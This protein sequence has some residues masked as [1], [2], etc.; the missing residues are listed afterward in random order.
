M[1]SILDGRAQKLAKICQ[2]MTPLYSN[3]KVYG[4]Y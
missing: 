4:L 1:D 2:F 3:Q